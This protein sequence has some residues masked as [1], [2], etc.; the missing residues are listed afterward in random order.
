MQSKLCQAEFDTYEFSHII[1]ATKISRVI[2]R[3]RLTLLKLGDDD[4]YQLI[5]RQPSENKNS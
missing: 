5:N 1:S 4:C 3:E 2:W